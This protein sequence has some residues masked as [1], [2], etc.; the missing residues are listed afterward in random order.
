MARLPPAR[1][2]LIGQIVRYVVTGVFL[3]AVQAAIYWTLATWV[4]VHP[5]LANFTGYLVAVT[6][7]FV[8]HGAFTFKGHGAGGGSAARSLRFVAVSL[9]SLALNAFWVWLCVTWLH[10]ATW[11]PIP[12]MG[13]VTPGLVFILNRQWVFR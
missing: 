3:T 13:F 2:A 1:R 5:Q 10:G 8:L 6:L 7:G 12:L 11:T 9:V 4:H